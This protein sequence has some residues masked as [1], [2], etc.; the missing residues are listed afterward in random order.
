MSVKILESMTSEE[1][2][3]G[4]VEHMIRTRDGVDLATDIYVPNGDDSKKYSA[5]LSRTCYDKSSTYTGLKYEA[6]TFNSRGFVF[7]AQDVRGKFR[8][9]GQTEPYEHDVNDAYDTVEWISRQPWSNGKVGAVGASY[10]GFTCWATVACGHPCVQAAIPQVTGIEMGGT[11]IAPNINNTVPSVISL[12]DILQI[13]TD[14]KGYLA[15]IDYTKSIEEIVSDWEKAVG[16]SWAASK[17]LESCKKSSWY[18]PYGSR[19]PYHNTNIPIL[20][21]QSWYDPG[22]CPLGMQD[23]R[24]FRSLPGSRGLHYLRAASEDHSTFHLED[25][26]KGSEASAYFAEEAIRRKQREDYTEMADFFDEHLNGA[27]PPTA[28]PHAR[29]H[30]GHLGWQETEEYP[31]SGTKNVKYYLKAASG[32]PINALSIQNADE[33]SLITWIHDPENP[34]PSTH[35]IESVWYLLMAYPDEREQASR[36]DVVTFR[37]E[38]LVEDFVFIGQPVLRLQLT[39]PANTTNLFVKLQD[40]LPDGT[41][42]PISSSATVVQKRAGS[43]VR[44]LLGDNAYRFQPGHCIQLQISASNYPH[45]LPHPGNDENPYY[46]TNR[47]KAEHSFVVGGIEGATLEMST[48]DIG[49]LQGYTQQ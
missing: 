44:I 18:N 36:P 34:V 20:H 10:Y 12:N 27:K 49:Q 42:R 23:W 39:Y 32:Q 26:G 29:W 22:L 35:D 25:V 9:T 33:S 38:P 4:A 30:V 16:P 48:L 14:N 28:R 13:W 11:H 8:S 7:V 43:T 46:A 6:E 17:F 19:H 5:I 21:W 2:V 47:V 15:E 24:H 45:A 37:T 41:T 31:P 1:P 3:A 40:I